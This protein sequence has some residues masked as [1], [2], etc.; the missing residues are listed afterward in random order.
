M[1]NKGMKNTL[2]EQRPDLKKIRPKACLLCQSNDDLVQGHVMPSFV[3]DYIKETSV[4]GVFRFGGNPN[5]TRQDYFKAY[6]FCKRCEN[7]MSIEENYFKKNIYYPA[8]KNNRREFHYNHQL[9]RFCMIQSFRVLVFFDLAYNELA[10][11][12]PSHHKTALKAIEEFRELI[13]KGYKNKSEYSNHIFFFD[14]ADPYRSDIQ[15]LPKRVNHYFLRALDMG[16]VRGTNQMYVYSKMGFIALFTLL[17]PRMHRG[18]IGTRIYANNGKLK[19][20]QQIRFPRLGQFLMSRAGIGDDIDELMS[21]RQM[22]KMEERFRKN[23]DKMADSET[24]RAV[25]ADYNIADIK[26]SLRE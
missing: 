24:A 9:S 10:K 18:M 7:I 20:P 19:T 4:T 6:M 12:K 11:L 25:F 22:A 14:L 1:G 16:I 8:A 3:V 26:K 2:E 5:L 23:I 15:E 21:D 13:F 17:V